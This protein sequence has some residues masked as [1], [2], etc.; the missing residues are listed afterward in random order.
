MASVRSQLLAQGVLQGTRIHV[1]AT[2][3]ALAGEK[4]QKWCL[5]HALNMKNAGKRVE[6]YMVSLTMK[7]LVVV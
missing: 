1:A 6:T 5:N 7:K 3:E 4:G 2:I